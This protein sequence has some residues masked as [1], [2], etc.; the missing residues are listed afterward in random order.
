MKWSQLDVA[1][2]VAGEKFQEALEIALDLIEEGSKDAELYN[3][4]GICEWR[5]GKIE[6]AEKRWEKAIEI[7]PS[8]SQACYNLGVLHSSMGVIDKAEKL[9][10]RAMECDSG[11]LDATIN[12]GLLLFDQKRLEEAETHFRQALETSPDNALLC[13]NLAVLLERSGRADEAG[14]FH[15]EAVRLAGESADIRFN[16]A[17]FIANSGRDGAIEEAKAAFLDVIKIDPRHFGAW[18][19]LGNL[20]FE[21]GFISAAHTAYSAAVTYHPKKSSAHVNLGN[22][23]LHMDDI[24]SAKRHFSIAL[25]IDPDQTEAHQGMASA[26][27]R[28][29]ESGPAAFHRVRGFGNSPFSSIAYRGAAQALP[30]LITASSLE[31]N[32]PWRFLIDRR[33]FHSTIVAVEFLDQA[34]PLPEH[35]LIFNAIGDADLCPEGLE[36]AAKV[37]KCGTAPVINHPD[38]VMKTGRLLNSERLGRL[39]GAITP[40]TR[41]VHKALLSETPARF[42]LLL[43]SPGFHGGNH[44]VRVESR[45]EMI[46]KADELPGDSLLLMEFLDARRDDGLHRKFRVMSID[47]RLYPVHLAISK[48]WKVHYFSSGMAGDASYREEEKAFLKDHEAVLGKKALAALQSISSTL[49]LDYFGMDFGLDGEGNVILYEANATMAV[50]PPGTA[51]KEWDYKRGPAWEAIEAGRR[52][53]LEKAGTTRRR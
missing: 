49:D 42:P 39:P 18:I 33:V 36:I 15:E 14:K 44:F 10:R 1:I 4:A 34:L 47:R 27:H 52:L 7:E 22:L 31:G 20:L 40:D 29:G 13:S 38:A 51:E 16:L 5:L 12:L 26:L 46:R 35:C 2:L 6:G 48:Q 30:L 8:L 45:E 53:F 41:L 21:T 11:N 50:I 28:E 32:V 24:P 9:F 37:A 43:R 3:L 17:N 19:N 23:L 25:D